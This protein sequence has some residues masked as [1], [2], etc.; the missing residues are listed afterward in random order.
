MSTMCLL[1]IHNYDPRVIS[2]YLLAQPPAAPRRGGPR[3]EG[4]ERKEDES[5]WREDRERISRGGDDEEGG[6]GGGEDRRRWRESENMRPPDAVSRAGPRQGDAPR[7]SLAL[8]LAEGSAERPSSQNVARVGR[9]PLLSVAGGSLRVRSY[10]ST[11]LPR[12]R[13]RRDVGSLNDDAVRGHRATHTHTH[14]HAYVYVH[15]R[16]TAR[17]T[18]A[19]SLVPRA[20]TEWKKGRERAKRRHVP[21]ARTAADDSSCSRERVVSRPDRADPLLPA[22]DHETIFPSFGAS[23]VR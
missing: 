13:S 5:A 6:G 19:T 4:A 2:E 3:T 7:R 1:S 23:G 20:R 14:I 9:R 16:E 15:E 12:D 8:F 22:A 18:G 11:L 17:H 10:R 21:R